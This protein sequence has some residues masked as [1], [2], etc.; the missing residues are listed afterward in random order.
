M[1]VKLPKLGEG[2]DSGVVVSIMVREGDSVQEGQTLLELENEKAVAP[3]PSPAAGVIAKLR[4]KEGDKVSA[5]QVILTLSGKGE[6]ATK[7]SKAEAGAAKPAKKTRVPEPELTAPAEAEPVAEFTR[8]PEIAIAAAPTV[9]RLAHELG[10]DLRRVEGTERGGRIGMRDLRTYIERLQKLAFTP[11]TAVAAAAAPPPTPV[12][13]I[14]FSKW[15]PIS[16]KPLS[17]LR[18]VIARRMTENW[19]TIPH[20]TQFDEADISRV[21]ELRKKHLAAY[22]ARG[23]RLTLMPFAIRAVV[24][25]LKKHPV[26]NSSLDDATG[27]LVLKDYF[28]IGVAVDTE[29]GL[30]VPVLR[31][32]DQKSLL[33]LATEVEELA[34]R[35]RDRKVGLEE[36]KGGTFTISNQGGIGGAQFTPIINKPEVAILGLGR[37]ALKAVVRER[38]IEPRLMLP[39]GLSYDH[40]VIDGGA[41]ARFIVDIVQAFELFSEAEMKF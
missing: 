9:R 33:Q 18:Q 39:L 5:G 26:F 22:E 12:E 1:D 4:V 15:G 34:A 7:E 28:H 11:K 20:V 25:T 35:A 38:K 31:N 6:V 29:A 41:A 3:I 19:I 23:A 13:S 2:A 32:A 10:I 17:Q 30:I 37:G 14:D 8:K 40:R 16:R 27:E 36:L 21:M 24:A